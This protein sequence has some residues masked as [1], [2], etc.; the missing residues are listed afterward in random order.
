MPRGT[1]IRDYTSNRLNF[2]C[3]PEQAEA[4]LGAIELAKSRNSKVTKSSWIR[5]ALNEKAARERR[6]G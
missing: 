5:D 6:K 1:L 4:W 2:R 3:T